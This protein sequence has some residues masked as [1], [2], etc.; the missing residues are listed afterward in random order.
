[1]ISDASE[2]HSNP[3]QECVAFTGTVMESLSGLPATRICLT[4]RTTG[5]TSVLTEGPNYDRSP[6][7]SPDGRLLAF[8]S[9]RQRAGSFQLY[10][11]N[12]E[13][14]VLHAAPA[15]TGWIEYLHWSPDGRRI[16]MGAAGLGADVAGPQ[17][18]VTTQESD[19][20]LPGWM[21]R[22]D[23][24]SAD[25]QWRSL[26]IY[27]VGEDVTRRLP[28][29]LN[30][31]EAVWCGNETVAAISSAAPE[32]GWWY[33]ATLNI[34]DIIGGTVREIYVPADQLGWPA[35]SPSGNRL[36]VVEAICSDRWNVAGDLRLIEVASGAVRTIETFGIDV[37]HLEWL[38][39]D[40]LVIGGLR[41]SES[42][43][44]IFDYEQDAVKEIW[45]SSELSTSG[46]GLKIGAY[47]EAGSFAL[48]AEGFNQPPT[49]ATVTDGRL[50]LV[51]TLG[52]ETYLL[53]DIQAEPLA[54]ISTD[55]AEIYGWLLRPR[56]A[57][58][59]LPLVM[60]IHGGPVSS[61]RPHWLARP[62]GLFMLMLLKRG[63]AVFLPNPR[64][65]AGR[66]QDFAR[67][68]VGDMVG[69][70][71][72]D[73]LS[74]IDWLISEGLALP[75]KLGTIGVSYGGLMT[76]WLVTQDQRFKAAVAVAPITNHVSE[77][78][79]S[80]LPHFMELFLND[81]YA[82]LAGSYYERS[83]ITYSANVVTPTLLICGALDRCTPPTEALQFYNA[84]IAH[85]VPSV[86]ATYP[87]EGHGVRAYPAVL[88]YSAR[89]VDWFDQYVM[90][91]RD[92][93]IDARRSERENV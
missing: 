89:V 66:G 60:N 61:W 81:H 29:T 16:L 10:L 51:K 87:E 76:A 50:A 55:G 45:A 93:H 47:G 79:T 17:G 28:L 77:H 73:L 86:L 59:A 23:A 62:R 69:A 38:T 21:P 49:V 65:S 20:A 42:V 39:E 80:N 54:W 84:L 32:E 33:T 1:M 25:T 43:A 46:H 11:L 70:D 64:G 12:L 19:G 57:A 13:T 88:D 31:W 74:G 37:A 7:F 34:V 15:V 41:A 72:T 27:D 82:N 71:T 4:D 92:T 30:A 22:I 24:G 14:K 48:I 40:R 83:P 6:K 35:A 2:I 63:Y 85:D 58:T 8:V 26:W 52:A 56:G 5:E 18:A 75:D 9:D 90:P 53:D 3:V 78:L 36:A 67:K 68:V 91:G 44:A